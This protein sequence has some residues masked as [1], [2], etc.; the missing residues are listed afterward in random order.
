[1]MGLVPAPPLHFFEIES[2]IVV[3]LLVVPENPTVGVGH[4]GEVLDVVGERAEAVLT[5]EQVLV[6]PALVSDV[7]KFHYGAAHAS[8]F[9][10][11]G[12]RNEDGERRAVLTVK[13]VLMQEVGH[14]VRIGQN[15][16]AFVFRIGS[17]IGIRMVNQLVHRTP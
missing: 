17:A 4:P 12:A 13:D 7:A 6:R 2:R 16:R 5:F 8:G 14:A 9:G 3:P 1:M 10:E 11:R 15:H